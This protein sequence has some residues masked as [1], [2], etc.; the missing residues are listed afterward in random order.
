MSRSI[1]ARM[2]VERSLARN[3]GPFVQIVASATILSAIDGFR[4]TASS[5]STMVGSASWRSSFPSFSSA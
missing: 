3:V 5:S 1:D 4:S 2:S